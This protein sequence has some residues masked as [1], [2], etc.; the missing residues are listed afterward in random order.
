MDV[1]ARGLVNFTSVIIF[2]VPKI[3]S[4]RKHFALAKRLTKSSY[5]ITLID[6]LWILVNISLAFFIYLPTYVYTLAVG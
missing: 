5:I 6:R 1:I 2:D 3:L 4:P